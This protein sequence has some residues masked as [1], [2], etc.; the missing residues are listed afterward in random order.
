MQRSCSIGKL[1]ISMS[2]LIFPIAVNTKYDLDVVFLLA[3]T[4]FL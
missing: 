1:S 2:Y 3:V 4:A